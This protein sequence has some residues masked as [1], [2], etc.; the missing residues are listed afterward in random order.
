MG[1]AVGPP[2]TSAIGMESS[3]RGGPIEAGSQGGVQTARAQGQGLGGSRTGGE[4]S[5]EKPAWPGL[6]DGR[7]GPPRLTTGPE[8]CDRY[9]PPPAQGREPYHRAL[10]GGG[11]TG[12]GWHTAGGPYLPQ[13]CGPASG[14]SPRRRC[15]G[16]GARTEYRPCGLYTHRL[17]EAGN[18]RSRRQQIRCLVRTSFLFSLCP[19]VAGSLG[20]FL[21]GH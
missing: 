2:Q 8:A 15:P 4:S 12:L 5:Q 21:Q 19:H 3:H 17:Q 7:P 20:S 16:S 6:G 1:Q 13:A 18:L 14:I 10:G 9:R 11:L